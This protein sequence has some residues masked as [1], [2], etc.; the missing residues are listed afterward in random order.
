MRSAIAV[1]AAK[2]NIDTALRQAITEMLQKH[3]SG[4]VTSSDPRK[5]FVAAREAVRRVVAAKMQLFGSANKAS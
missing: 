5:V 3:Y 2:V 4:P 1:G